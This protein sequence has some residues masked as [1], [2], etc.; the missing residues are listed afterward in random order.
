MI[1]IGIVGYGYWGPNLARCAAEADGCLLAA[2]ADRSADALARAQ[3]RHAAATLYEDWPLLLSDPRVEAVVVATPVQ[4]HFE[5]ALAALRAGKHVLVE[6]PMTA[7][8]EQARILVREA[9]RRKL[10]LMVDHTFIYTGAIT[11]IRELI[12]NGSMGEIF[13]YDATRIN[14]GLFQRDV[15][16][17]WDLAVHD[18]AI[19]DHLLDAKPVAV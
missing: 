3:K 18:L 16:V 13:Y 12:S 7:T 5:I 6:K 19:L 17:L 4:S 10:T 1:G 14:L 11:K 15:N 9:R 8:T 2:I